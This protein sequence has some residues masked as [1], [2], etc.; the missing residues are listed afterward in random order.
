MSYPLA[1][2]GPQ[3]MSSP[4]ET[5]MLLIQTS[6][7]CWVYY[8]GMCARLKS[9]Y[10]AHS[11]KFLFTTSLTFLFFQSDLHPGSHISLPNP[12]G[13]GKKIDHHNLY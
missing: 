9:A 5:A 13:H 6:T 8:A 12:M 7:R 1:L 4:K 3:V 2:A 11:N 10:Q